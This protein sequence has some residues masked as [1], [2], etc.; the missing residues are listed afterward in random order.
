MHAP[1]VVVGVVTIIATVLLLRTRLRHFAY[2]IMLLGMSIAVGFFA[3]AGVVL[4][5]ERHAI[6]TGLP[7]PAMPDLS[8]IPELLLPSLSLVIVGLSFGAGVAQSYPARDGNVGDPSRDFFGQGVANLVSSFFQCLPSGASM[9]RT[10][11]VVETGAN[12]R[13]ANVFT[14]LTMLAI[15]LTVA[16]WAERVPLAVVAALLMVLGWTAIDLQRLAIVWQI[17]RTE[18]A[19]ML[20]TAILT[21]AA[22]PPLA[23]LAGVILSFVMFIHASASSIVVMH[24][25][26]QGDGL[27][28]ERPLPETFPANA[29]TVLRMHGYLFFADISTIEQ[30]LAPFLRVE[31]AALVLSLRGYTSV[32]STGIL[33]LERFAQQMAQVGNRL[34]LADVSDEIRQEFER[35]AILGKLGD[36]NVIAAFADPQESIARAFKAA[37]EPT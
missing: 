10:A 16:D 31:R 17:N 19:T 27:F 18:R 20:V 8:A 7:L 33:F 26:R 3:P 30:R 32:G 22:S 24:L 21:V 36:H 29:V 13:W 12:T 23:I 4:A 35:T 11:Y 9:S 25:V 15:V 5:G 28:A 2:L 34:V 1:T 14:G 6:A 37:S